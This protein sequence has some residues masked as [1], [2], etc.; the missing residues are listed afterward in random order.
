MRLPAAFVSL[1]LAAAL[2]GGCGSSGDGTTGGG[3]TA[4]AGAA[5]QACAL[6]AGGIDGLRV[7]AVSCGEGQRVASGWRA[8]AQCA[9][10]GSRSGCSV[11]GYRC[12][13]TASDR[14]WSVDCAKP[15][16]SIAFTVRRG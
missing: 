7:T 16:K 14:G 6:N 10:Q 13:A 1:L 5:A 8:A 12:Q 3:A 15:G 4:P 2:L 11:R 9:K